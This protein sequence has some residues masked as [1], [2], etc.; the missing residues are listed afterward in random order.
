MKIGNITFDKVPV[1]LAPMA[2]T[3]SVTFRELCVK[4]GASYG[5]TELVSA[6]SLVYGKLERSYRYMR[7][8]PQEE[9]VT[10][11]QLF[12]HEA[13]DFEEAVRIICADDR[14]KDV[15]I[16]D[17]NMGCPVTKV[18][19][20]GAGSAL[21]DD[22]QR[23]Y[24]IVKSAVRAAENFGKTVTVKT[25][26]GF[27][28]YTAASDDFVK[29]LA[30]EGAAM[31]CVHGRTAKQMYGGS[32]DWEAIAHMR[33]AV[34]SEGAA[35]FA[36]GD[37]KDEE[38]AGRILEVTGADGI[39]V[40]RAAMGNP[41]LF[42]RIRASLDGKAMPEEPSLKE[43]CEMLLKELHG[44]VACLGEDTAVKEMRSVMPHYFKGMRG[45][46]EIKISLCRAGSVSEVEAILKGICE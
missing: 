42:A 32:A 37:I 24:K 40:G 3:S 36:N 1:C 31:V 28:E 14:L 26:T 35:F 38:S 41:W 45:A 30:A 19:K 11:I 33:E 8:N 5:P 34:A 18:V 2:G 20:T 17:I 22:P 25:R 6:R 4:Q 39:M 21:L 10:A 23:A 12:G 9:G 15:D 7:I 29:G 13:S 16:I 46:A 43:K 27:K 44:G